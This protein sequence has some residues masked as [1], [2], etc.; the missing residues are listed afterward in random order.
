MRELA[1]MAL[2]THRKLLNLS[3]SDPFVDETE[4][5]SA[6]SREMRAIA[7]SS[8]ETRKALLELRFGEDG[9]QSENVDEG[10]ASLD[11]NGRPREAETEG[12]NGDDPGAQASAEDPPKQL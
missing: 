7:R 1:V 8:I 10:A 3:V 6:V 5:L 11:G 9:E 12:T 4:T 2:Q